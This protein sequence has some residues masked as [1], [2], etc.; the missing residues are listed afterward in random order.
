M[1]AR[2]RSWPKL[3]R[4]PAICLVG[5]RKR[6]DYVQNRRLP[7]QT[8]KKLPESKSEALELEKRTS[9]VSYRE[10]AHIF[11]L[12]HYVRKFL[13]AL[14]L[15]V[16]PYATIIDTHRMQAVLYKGHTV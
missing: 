12:L 15:Q 1:T 5:L 10:A 6:K 9:L 2:Q 16:L 4:Y 7:A 3:R 13:W 14:C 8:G 11:L